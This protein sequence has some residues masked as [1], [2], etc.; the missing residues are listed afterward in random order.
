[1]RYFLLS[2]LFIAIFFVGYSQSPEN[3]INAYAAGYH[4]L[5]LTDSSR[6][7]KPA[8]AEQDK[9]HFR[10]LEIDV[11]YPAT[12]PVSASPM[13][14]GDFLNLLEERSNRFQ[15]DTLYKNLSSELTQ[16]TCANLKIDDTSKLVQLK[17]RTYKDAEP[18]RQ[19]FPLIVYMCSYNGMSYENVYLFEWLASHGY[20][21]ACI[22]SV[23]RYPGNMSMKSAD[24]ME[25]V[26]D[27]IFTI[28]A[29]TNDEHV[30]KSNIGVMGYSWGGLAALEL[31][32]DTKDIKAVLSIDGSEMHYYGDLKTEDEDFNRIRESTIMGKR[33][34]IPYT[35]FESDNKQEGREVD[36]IFNVM[37]LVNT[38]KKYARFISATHEDFSCLFSLAVMISGKEN[39]HSKLY[40]YFCELSLDYFNHYLK[41]QGDKFSSDLSSLIG[42]RIADSTYPVVKKND[43]KEAQIIK[44]T[45]IDA[46]TG[47]PLAY[48]NVG[49]AEKNIGTVTDHDGHF[50]LEVNKESL[51]DTITFSMIGYQTQFI[52][53][54]KFLKHE[55]LSSVLLISKPAEL[56]EVIVSAKIMKMKVLGNTSAS[57]FI[58]FGFP[59]KFLGSEAGVKINLG[60]KPVLLKNFR[61]T[62]SDNRLD[63]AVFRLNI[64][65]FQHGR[66]TEN[67]LQQNILIPVGKKTGGYMVNLSEYK[68]IMKDD[69]LVALEWIEGSSTQDHGAIFLSAGVLNSSTWHRVTSQGSWKKFSSI[70]AGFNITVQKLASD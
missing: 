66:P 57:R 34:F 3:K 22:T 56:K 18:I 52:P 38:E 16:Y 30:D 24:L 29:F 14:F 8:T 67:I 45:V 20:I 26:N 53:V 11:W 46:K 61:F 33:L 32:L 69:I 36:S 48:V 64:Y 43:E 28:R 15:D 55:V 39:N 35:Y 2:T 7:Y 59:L 21:V 68:L 54:A 37:F 65:R 70:G 44:A 60:K 10:P 19:K 23:G 27:G 49:I 1:M 63:T 17:T 62:V 4:N 50:V 41:N 12:N 5:V 58:S 31:V 51:I 42:K 13:K 6:V 9:F 47:E 40:R 25:Q